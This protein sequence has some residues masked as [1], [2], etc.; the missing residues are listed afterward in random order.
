MSKI[1]T[2]I[3]EPQKIYD[4]PSS[5]STSD[6][7]EVIPVTTSDAVIIEGSTQ[8]TLTERLA[9][10]GS[11]TVDV[12]NTV[13]SGTDIVKLENNE[14][15]CGNFI[16]TIAKGF[17]SNG[18]A[19]DVQV[20]KD[21]YTPVP[22]I[23]QYPAY[24]M[25]DEAGTLF[26][27]QH[28]DGGNAF[29]L[30][31]VSGQLFFHNQLYQVYKY[32]NNTWVSFPCVAI[33]KFSS[34]SLETIFPYN[35]WWWDQI[36]WE[37]TQPDFPAGLTISH[38][39]DTS[40]NIDYLRVDKGS[41]VT[42]SVVYSLS[43]GLFKKP[44]VSFAFGNYEGSSD[45][46]YSNISTNIIPMNI[47]SSDTQNF[48][49]TSSDSS[50]DIYSIFNDAISPKW[51]PV[52]P[53]SFTVTFP[54]AQ[55]INKYTISTG[56][57]TSFP[58]EW[59]VLGS[60]NNVDWEVIDT[61]NTNSFIAGST[62]TFKTTN[63]NLYTNIRVRFLSSTSDSNLNIDQI[64]FYCSTPK[65][66]VFVVSDGNNT[67]IMTSILSTPLLSSGLTSY[68][69]IGTVCLDEDGYLFNFYP[70]KTLSNDATNNYEYLSGKINSKANTELT[71]VT[72]KGLSYITN[73]CYP[74]SLSG[75]IVSKDTVYFANNASYLR[76]L[77]ASGATIGNI[78]VYTSID[79]SDIANTVYNAITYKATPVDGVLA[80]TLVIPKGF[81]FKY[82]MT[83]GDVDATLVPMASSNL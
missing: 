64:R 44:A 83:T 30:A 35:T 71:N 67:D 58:K 16:A 66:N 75:S 70:Q 61:Q 10:L 53:V 78:T 1:A 42:S 9:E 63:N 51:A 37:E 4:N 25:V 49:I 65:L 32:E 40:N 47:T 52:L 8:E 46:S 18:R 43:N 59:V 55:S 26:F 21:T 57:G 60:N 45:G 62:L 6:Y 13:I 33:A 82:T 5:P 31:A 73:L 29:P 68:H 80:F 72:S 24:L 15:V 38:W 11:G 36:I 34:S 19:I 28:F 3:T 81:Y 20:K 69:Q 17:N 39:A 27:S 74:K 50:T 79:K 7:V 23:P 22:T 56:L 41:L 48:T 12:R 76:V 77:S 14:F 2:Y 54:Q